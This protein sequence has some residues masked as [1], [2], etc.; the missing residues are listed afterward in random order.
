MDFLSPLKTASIVDATQ[1][2]LRAVQKSR[3]HAD[4]KVLADLRKR[5][6]VTMSKAITFVISRGPKYARVMEKE[7]TD[8]THDM[9]V[10]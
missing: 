7:E 8:L 3:T 1:N 4:A 10:K 6:L 5:K 2:D 9:L